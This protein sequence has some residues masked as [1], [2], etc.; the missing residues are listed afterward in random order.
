M[1]FCFGGGTSYYY[2]FC[3]GDI[4]IALRFQRIICYTDFH[5]SVLSDLLFCCSPPVICS[6]DKELIFFWLKT[7]VKKKFYGDCGYRFWLIF[8]VG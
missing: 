7:N 4:E 8:E 3:T 6:W 1:N 5:R 2:Y